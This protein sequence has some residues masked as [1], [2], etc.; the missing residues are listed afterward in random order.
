[1]G[2]PVAMGEE[3]DRGRKNSNQA[4]HQLGRPDL[5]QVRPDQ[6]QQFWVLGHQ[7]GGNLIKAAAL[8]NGHDP[9]EGPDDGK[10]EALERHGILVSNIATHRHIEPCDKDRK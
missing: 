1:M 7:F 2:K 5:G 3:D 9:D 10:D 8:Y 6:V 4:G